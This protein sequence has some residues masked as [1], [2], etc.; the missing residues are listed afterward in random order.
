VSLAVPRGSAL[1]VVGPNGAGK[2]TLF[3]LVLG[4]LRPTAGAV[5]VA[6]I[7]AR[8]YVRE[9]GVGYLPER[10]GPP[11]QWRVRE[12]LRGFARADGVAAAAAD[13]AL[14]RWGLSA[15]AER[16]LGTLSRG[17]LQRVGLAQALLAPRAL[18]VLD[19]PTEGLDPLWRVRL[20]EAIQ[21]L[22]ARGATVLIASHD[23]EEVERMCERA[24]LLQGGRVRETLDTAAT[25]APALYRIALA[26]PSDALLAAFPAAA[27]DE[28]ALVY[29]VTVSDADELSARLAAAIAGGARIV[30]VTPVHEPFEARVQRALDPEHDA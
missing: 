7:P 14:E 25:A 17:L 8:S 20:R 15:D 5:T 1:A 26:T 16:E 21:A 19:E 30:A 10:F 12:T 3:G 28:H 22:R 9:H 11:R 18:V 29:E 6:G 2:T 24:V 23:L 27:A 13:D 4:F